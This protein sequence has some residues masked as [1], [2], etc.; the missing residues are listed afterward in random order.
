MRSRGIATLTLTLSHW[1]GRGDVGH[2]WVPSPAAR[3]R[4]RVSAFAASRR[5]GQEF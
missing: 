4:D 3:E 2:R 5:F 1:R